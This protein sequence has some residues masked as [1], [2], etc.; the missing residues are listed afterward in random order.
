MQTYLNDPKNKPIVFMLSAAVGCLVAAI[1][2]EA[3]L[4]VLPTGEAARSICLTIDVSGSMAGP[5][6]EEMKQAAQEFVDQCSGD[7]MAITIFSSDARIL[8]P[9]S[10]N[11]A[12]LKKNI[13]DLEAFGG[14][15]FQRA[16]EVSTQVLEEHGG[17]NPALLVFTD[18]ENSVGDANRAVQIAG[19]LRQQGVSIFAVATLD[20]DVMYLA[21]LTGDRNRVFFAQSGELRTAFDQVERMIATTIGSGSGSYTIAFIATA[22]WTIFVALGIAIALVVIQNYFLKKPLLPQ[23][24][25]T[26]V[27][28]GA[29]LAGVAAGFVAQTAM[30]ALSAIYLGEL[31]RMLAWSVLGGLLAF[32]MVF[33]IP[34]LDKAK[35]LGFGALGGFLGSI[36]FLMMTAI[37]GETGGRWIGAFIL[38]ACIGLL[39]AMV[40][41]M[42]RKVW[43]MVVYDPRN[44][45]QVNLGSQAVTAGSGKNDTVPI[46]GVEAKAAS[47]LVVGDKVQYTDAHGT[48]SLVPGNRV[49]V[50]KVELVV[51]SKEVPFSPSKFYPMKMSRARELRNKT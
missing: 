25:A 9:F 49:K 19:Q 23:E 21:N 37:A 7:N 17:R 41:T 1:L 48:Q 8:V 12:E 11:T 3:F 30:T 36:G 27:A 47:F 4:F 44:F 22:G 2:A 42:Y 34:N 24:Q 45:S 51:C 33:V 40:E 50:G 38:G 10:K 31:G 39:V 6:M 16:L 29:I 20:A 35:A 14:T 15:N 5:L 18:G 43:L 26:A 32:G 13:G 28:I 46:A